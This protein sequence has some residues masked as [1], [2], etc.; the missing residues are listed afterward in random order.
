M[1]NPGKKLWLVKVHIYI[2]S[3]KLLT[4][5]THAQQQQQRTRD[6]GCHRYGSPGLY[7]CPIRLLR[8]LCQRGLLDQK[9]NPLRGQR[10]LPAPFAGSRGRTTQRQINR[11][12]YQRKRHSRYA[13]QHATVC[14]RCADT[15][16][17]L[18]CGAG[19]L[20][21]QFLQRAIG[22]RHILDLC[23]SLTKTWLAATCPPA[24][25]A[26]GTSLDS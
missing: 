8:G 9:V 21:G 4:I 25:V 17:L 22:R 13:M 14:L 11:A 16:H 18:I 6:T 19:W 7:T 26:A 5:R 2:S 3:W 10:V 20:S 1:L 24:N 12:L 23:L 15:S